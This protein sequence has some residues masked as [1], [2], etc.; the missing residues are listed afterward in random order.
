MSDAVKRFFDGYFGALSECDVE[1][2]VPFFAPDALN[3]LGDGTMGGRDDLH[4]ALTG[5]CSTFGSVKFEVTNVE[6][7]DKRSF[8]ATLRITSPRLREPVGF[9]DAFRFRIVRCSGNSRKLCARAIRLVTSI[10]PAAVAAQLRP[11]E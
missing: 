1:R 10:N 3:Y 2:A 9:S 8:F 5:F 7:V 4:K 11:M 6:R